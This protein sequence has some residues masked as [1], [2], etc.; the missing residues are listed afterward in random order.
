[1]TEDGFSLSE[2][3]VAIVGLGLMGASLAMDLRGYC[4]EIL[5]ASRSPDT[6]QYALDHHIVDRIV[7]FSPELECD[8]LILAA[9]VRTILRQLCSLQKLRPE[10]GSKRR[11][12]VLDLGSTKK[13][14]VRAM[15]DL[16][17]AF[18]P[19]GGHPMCG[20]EVAGIRNAE[21]GLYR[22]KTFILTPLDRTTP[23]ALALIQELVDIIGATSLI[24]PAEKQDELVAMTSHLPYLAASALMRTALS[25]EEPLLWKVAASGFRDT[26][27][28]AASD[29][30]MMMDILLT[31]REAILAALD[32][33]QK[34]MN[35]L[36]ASLRKGDEEALRKCLSPSQ[37][38]RMQLFK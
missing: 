26:T 11:A 32:S 37:Q 17:E 18:D 23:Q 21:I 24:L 8:L 10:P 27:R 38:K 14:I 19:I 2:A 13:E 12:V 20:K 15:E 1:M 3:R 30:T 34:G 29:L 9:P 22:E 33:Y 16:P 35:L 28:L 7:E 5:G 36:A 6:L 31:N 4:A 25:K